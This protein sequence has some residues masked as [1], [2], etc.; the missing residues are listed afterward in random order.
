VLT[1]REKRDGLAK[2]TTLVASKGDPRRAASAQ[3]DKGSSKRFLAVRVPLLRSIALEDFHIEDRSTAERLEFWDYVWR[4]SPY[5]EVMSVPLLYYY[6]KG[7]RIEPKTF[8][9]V[10]HWI[11]RVDDWGHCDTL[12]GVYSFLNHNDRRTVMP[13]L[14]RLNRSDNLW[15]VRAALVSL[16]HYSGRNAAYLPPGEVFPLLEPHLANSNR[17]IANAL[18]WVLREMRRKYRDEVDAYVS[19]N[20]GRLSRIALAK[21]KL[22]RFAPG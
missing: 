18:G 9:V 8:D 4:R 15:C 6:A 22:T 12:S 5:Y 2:L 17:Y 21:A 19:R 14:R 10:R 1:Q 3:R 13:F 16:I 20:A 7:T 11:D